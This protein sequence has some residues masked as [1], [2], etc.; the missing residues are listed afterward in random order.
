VATTASKETDILSRLIFPVS[1]EGA[2][3][4]L[5]IEFS[6]ADRGRMR[7]LLEKGNRGQRTM[8]ENEEAADY[9]RIGHVLSTLKSFA[10]RR[11]SS[12]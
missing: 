2:R 6:D 10:R 12:S 11:L 4:I 9:E 7:F 5:K 3:D 1:A 8:A